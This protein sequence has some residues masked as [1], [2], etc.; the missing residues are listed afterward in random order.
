MIK[1][2]RKVDKLT[3]TMDSAMIFQSLFKT[4]LHQ[5]EM[6]FLKFSTGGNR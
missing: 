6:G 4:E 3:V 2:S 5:N 1:I